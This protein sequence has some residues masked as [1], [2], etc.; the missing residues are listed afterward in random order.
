VRGVLITALVAATV[1]LAA[2]QQRPVFR[3]G[4]D[5]VTAEVL[6][7][8]R[9]GRPVTDLTSA[10]F[11][12]SADGRPRR[13]LAAEYIATASAPKGTASARPSTPIPMAVSNAGQNAGRSF[14]FLIDTDEIQFGD[15]AG[16]MQSIAAFVDGVGR[17]D[18]VGVVA[19]PTGVPRVDLT[20]D[21]EAVKTAVRQIRGRSR[22]RSECDPTPGEAV[23]ITQGQ[24]DAY[25]ARVRGLTMCSLDILP[26]PEDSADR[27]MEVYLRHARQVFDVAG[28]MAKAMSPLPGSKTIV[29]VSESL[30]SDPGL[31]RD[32]VRF[33]AVLEQARVRLYALKLDAPFV[34]VTA[35][36]PTTL[37]G[38]LDN[39]LGLNGLSEAAIAGGGETFRGTANVTAG[40]RQI[41]AQLGGYYEI[42]F[43]RDAMDEDNA[44]LDL[45]IRVTRPNTDVR[46]RNRVTITGLPPEASSPA[47]AHTAIERL[48]HAV[49]TD[50]AIPLDM[51]TYVTGPASTPNETSIIVVTEIGLTDAP[52]E[53]IGVEISDAAGKVVKDSF[54]PAPKLTALERGPAGLHVQGVTEARFL[55]HQVRSGDNHRQGRE[56]S[57]TIHG[58][59]AEDQRGCGRR[60]CAV[61]QP[62]RRASPACEDHAGDVSTRASCG[63]QWSCDESLFDPWS[64]AARAGG[65]AC[66][67]PR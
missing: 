46:Y 38:M 21:R 5:I 33:G 50:P 36:T 42:A 56:H 55:S 14:L 49:A 63:R 61:R 59:D 30:L 58:G 27:V 53:A 39:R 18:L 26:S 67:A 60:H 20:T 3:A 15:G 2:E 16:A 64:I 28:N 9:S 62:V 6:A 41:D 19:L 29:L 47:D 11:S 52:L 34:D 22:K 8:D 1:S 37:T 17:D 12:V 13:V 51:G 32:L 65:L 4:I 40:L 57:A 35:Q 25:L 31:A 43:E 23:A 24:N 44:R 45:K 10:D 66:A 7:L 54:D 48:L